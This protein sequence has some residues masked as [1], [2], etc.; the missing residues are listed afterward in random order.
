[1]KNENLNNT[2]KVNRFFANTSFLL[3]FILFIDILFFL[4]FNYVFNILCNMGA[5]IHDNQNIRQYIG[6][7]NILPTLNLKY[8]N[9]AYVYGFLFLIIVIFDIYIIYQVKLSFS[10]QELNQGQKGTMRWTTLKEIKEQFHEVPLK[11]EEYDGGFGI[12]IS[13]IKD[14]LYLD[15]GKSNNLVIGTSRSGKGEM[16]VFPSIDVYSRIKGIENKPSMI[17]ADPKVELYRSSKQRLEKRGYRVKLLNLDDPIH[18]LGYNPLSLVI[19]Y[20][21]EGNVDKAQLQARTFA[22]GIFNTSEQGTSEPI[23]QNTATDLFTAL[24]IAVVTDSIDKDIELNEIR[25]K[26]WV[27]KTKKW[28]NLPKN[29]RKIAEERYFK[30]Q[31]MNDGR[32]IFLSDRI[33]FI[34]DYVAFFE[35]FPN[36]KK[37]TC[38]SCINFFQEFINQA[39]VSSD[40]LEKDTFIQTALDEYFYGRPK[41]DFA[42]SLYNEIKSAGTRTKGSVYINMQ[43]AL[44]IFVID[45]IARLTAEN[46]IDIEDFGFS[47]KPV[48]LFLGIPSE[49]K[50]NWFLATTFIAQAYQHLVYLAKKKK[51]TVD[52]KIKFI[53]DEGGNFPPIYNFSSFLNVC[54]GIGISFDFYVQSINQIHDKYD[55]DAKSVLDGFANWIYIKAINEETNETFSKQIGSK[56]MIAVQRNGARH[57]LNKSFTEIAEEKPLILPGELDNLLEGECVIKRYIKRHDNDG[58]SIKSY[59]IIN[60]YA[61]DNKISILEKIQCIK[62]AYKLYKRDKN[63]NPLISYYNLEINKTKKYLGNALLSRWE[64]LIEDFPNPQEIELKDINNESR[65]HIDWMNN[66]FDPDEVLEKLQSK[67][68]ATDISKIHRFLELPNYDKF[69]IYLHNQALKLDCKRIEFTGNEYL[70]EV[71]SKICRLYKY[72]DSNKIISSFE[73]DIKEIERL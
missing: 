43:S 62:R 50:S 60:E 64:Y 41:L 6:I 52:R 46:D 15:D 39:P 22:Y 61:D 49:D 70:S 73:K 44:S 1:M 58:V 2:M 5:I 34:P 10:D 48:A 38:F 3:F 17:I 54:I 36:E 69:K 28:N 21:K 66:V 45:S 40:A 9:P 4:I 59:P 29:L 24:I 68:V 13:R 56:T 16:F 31:D 20:Y 32:D 25:R 19:K 12:I 72:P 51:G 14:R 23:W 55:K 57:S 47:D 42:R 30:A 65:K 33:E 37:I 35:I 53:I 71:Y 63:R 11:N 27:E 67:G 26:A 18:S 8:G 7:D